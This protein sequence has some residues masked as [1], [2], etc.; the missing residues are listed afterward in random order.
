MTGKW[1][2]GDSIKFGG[3]GYDSDTSY[4]NS[5]FKN[6]YNDSYQFGTYGIEPYDEY[7]WWSIP[8]DKR[9]I[10]SSGP[11][12]F[13]AGTSRDMY[14]AFVFDR[15]GEDPEVALTNVQENIDVIKDLFNSNNLDCGSLALSVNE[16]Q[17]IESNKLNVYPNPFNDLVYYTY[18]GSDPDATMHVYDLVGHELMQAKVKQGANQLDLNKFDGNAFLLQ[19]SDRE[20]NYTQKVI[21]R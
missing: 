14:L 18:E 20:A 11:F 7:E 2:N 21:R 5:R 3:N 15:G 17:I 10:G 13:E 9:M 19:L 8:S 12:T 16:N 4:A 1:R 6:S